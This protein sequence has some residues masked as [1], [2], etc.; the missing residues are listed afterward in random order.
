MDIYYT[1][2]ATRDLEFLPLD[3]AETLTDRR[4]G[5]YRFRIGD[6]RVI[7]DVVDGKIYVLKI[8]RRDE[9]YR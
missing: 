6:Y 9:V 5:G 8:R 1:R 7:F 3:F 4:E 2:G